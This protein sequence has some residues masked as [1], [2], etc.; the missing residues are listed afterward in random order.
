MESKQFR[1]L[2]PV[3]LRLAFH[4]LV[5]NFLHR[6]SY[7]SRSSC[8]KEKSKSQGNPSLV[9]LNLGKFFSFLN[10]NGNAHVCA[11]F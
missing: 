5:I 2:S 7:T 3:C 6:D 4:L 1:C 8:L 9:S 11:L 10:S